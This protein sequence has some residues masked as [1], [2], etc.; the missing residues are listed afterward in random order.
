MNILCLKFY[1]SSLF[2]RFVYTI[3]LQYLFTNDS[4]FCAFPTLPNA[5]DRTCMTCIRP[6]KYESVLLLWSQFII[7]IKIH[8]TFNQNIFCL[9]AHLQ[10]YLELYPGTKKHQAYSLDPIWRAVTIKQ[11]GGTF[12]WK[13]VKR[14]SR[15]KQAGKIFFF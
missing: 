15:V 13:I 11:S 12:H 4:A 9:S 7:M 2:T 5:P 10:T 6:K 8:E 1:C 3:C 14:A